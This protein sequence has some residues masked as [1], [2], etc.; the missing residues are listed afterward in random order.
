M[1]SYAFNDENPPNRDDIMDSLRT[2]VTCYMVSQKDD[3]LLSSEFL[4]LLKEGG[5]FVVFFH[6]MMILERA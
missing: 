5:N 3:V 1:I 2:A 4:N 6:T